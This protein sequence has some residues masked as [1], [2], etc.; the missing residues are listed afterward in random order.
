MIFLLCWLF[1]L[2]LFF[3]YRIDDVKCLHAHTADYLIRQNKNSIGK[4]VIEKLIERGVDPSGCNDCWQQC[5]VR[6]PK[7]DTVWWYASEKNRSKLTQRR[8]RNRAIKRKI[9]E[10][11]NKLESSNSNSDSENSNNSD[12]NNNNEKSVENTEINHKEVYQSNN[13]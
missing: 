3:F 12:S 13:K 11:R 7:E 8:Q 6:I 9:L 5:D 4:K 2:I 10:K 1:W